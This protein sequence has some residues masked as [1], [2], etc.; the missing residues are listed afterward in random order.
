MG[1]N[2]KCIKHRIELMTTSYLINLACY[3]RCVFTTQT[4]QALEHCLHENVSVKVTVEVHMYYLHLSNV[5]S[6]LLNRYKHFSVPLC[7][8]MFL[9]LHS[10]R[11]HILFNYKFLRT[12]SLEKTLMLGKIEG[13]R[14]RG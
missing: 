10:Y 2:L 14:R 6:L 5:N 12:N 1:I 11:K 9:N 3:S 8:L 4:F 13:W 7:L